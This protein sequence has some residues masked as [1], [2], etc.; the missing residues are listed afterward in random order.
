MTR[1]YTQEYDIYNLGIDNFKKWL[2]IYESICDFKNSQLENYMISFLGKLEEEG[3]SIIPHKANFIIKHINNN[4]SNRIEVIGEFYNFITGSF[5]FKLS[6]DTFIKKDDITNV[7]VQELPK[8]DNN[9]L[10]KIF[11]ILLKYDVYVSSIDEANDKK[12]EEILTKAIQPIYRK[13][14][15]ESLIGDSD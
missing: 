7:Y 4:Y 12:V 6:D 15:I 1:K 8:K 11:N 9:E 2:P 3:D 13:D 14:K 5:E 10:L